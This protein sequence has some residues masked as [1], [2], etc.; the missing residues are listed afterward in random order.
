[1]S[2]ETKLGE[3]L[4]VDVLIDAADIDTADVTS[5]VFVDASLARKFYAKAQTQTSLTVNKVLTLTLMQATDAAGT[6]AK[7]I[8][9]AATFTATGTAKASVAAECS[10]DDL[11][12]ENGFTFVGVKV[13]TDLGSAVAGSVVLVSGSKRF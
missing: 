1:M 13:G 9:T 3:V 12:N 2:T 6:G 5:T 7:A 8:G 10:A 11:D 4:N